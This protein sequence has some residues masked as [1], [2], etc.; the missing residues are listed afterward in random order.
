MATTT[1]IIFYYD[2]VPKYKMTKPIKE[3]KKLKK[4]IKGLSSG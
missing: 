1:T 2:I 4:A 3:I